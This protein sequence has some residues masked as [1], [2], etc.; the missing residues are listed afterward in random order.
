MYN[1]YMQ[2]PTENLLPVPANE[3]EHLLL[4]AG[5]ALMHL[6]RLRR[7]MQASDKTDYSADQWRDYHAVLKRLDAAIERCLPYL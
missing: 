3:N 7:Q 4:K 6:H 2:E 1:A 5:V